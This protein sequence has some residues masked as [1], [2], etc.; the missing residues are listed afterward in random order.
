[1]SWAPWWGVGRMNSRVP[2]DDVARRVLTGRSSLIGVVE[3]KGGYILYH[4][5]VKLSGPRGG[6]WEEEG[7]RTC[8]PIDSALTRCTSPPPPFPLFFIDSLSPGNNV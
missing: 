5:L 7:G 4:V 8:N 3:V 2:K 6:G 1:L